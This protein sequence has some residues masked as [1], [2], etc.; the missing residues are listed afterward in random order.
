MAAESTRFKATPFCHAP[1]ERSEQ[2]SA[3]AVNDKSVSTVEEAGILGSVYLQRLSVLRRADRSQ[4]RVHLEDS[5][6]GDETI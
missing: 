3:P 5:K 6:A 1:K 2:M 4:I